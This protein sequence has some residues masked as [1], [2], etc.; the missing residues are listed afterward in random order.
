MRLDTGIELNFS[1]LKH[2]NYFKLGVATQIYLITT[3]KHFAG[4]LTEFDSSENKSGVEERKLADLI[5][6][7]L[8]IM[9]HY[10]VVESDKFIDM[11]NKRLTG[12]CSPLQQVCNINDMHPLFQGIY[13]C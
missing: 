12:T 3:N 5:E 4:L 10:Q 2:F 7:T 1:D 9:I 6:L 13:K 11:L 8:S